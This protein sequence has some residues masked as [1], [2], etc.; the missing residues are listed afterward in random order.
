MTSL[1]YDVCAIGNALVDIIADADDAFLTTHGIAKGG[2]TLIDT[3]R[4]ETLYGLIGKTVEMS[5]GSAGNTV[6]GIASLGGTPAYMGKVKND[7][8]GHTYHQ[9]MKTQGVHF[10]TSP[11]TSGTPTGQC[12]ILVTPD[13]QRSM[14]TYLGAA[15]EFTPNDIDADVIRNSQVIYLEGYLFDQPEAKKAFRHA[16][17]IARDAGRKVSL[18]LSD[19]F[20]VGRYREEFINLIKTDIDILFAN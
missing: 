19:A 12:I 17:S 8:L 1:T 15:V 11:A 3:A 5:G 13:A 6:A 10:A 14:N 7:A 2:M 20:C 9:D 4:A 18:T 16:A